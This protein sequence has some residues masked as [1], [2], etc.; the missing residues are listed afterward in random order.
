MALIKIAEHTPEWHALRLK[1]VGGSEIASLFH[2]QA[3]WG[4]SEY[5]LFCVKSGKIPAPPVDDSPGSRVWVGIRKEPT[6]AAMGAEI[7]GWKISKGLYAKDDT[8]SGM[9][10]SLDY[11]IDEPGPE[12]VKLGFEGPGVLQVKNVDGQVYRESWTSD[13]PPFHIL[14]QLQHEIACSGFTWGVI[15]PEVRG[16]EYPAFRYSARPKMI[17]LIRERVSAFWQRVRDNK[18]PLV[19]GTD[20]TAAALA[21]MFPLRAG[22]EELDLSTDNEIADICVGILTSKADLKGAEKMVTEYENRLKE[23]MRTYRRA[24]CNGYSIKGIYT[25]ANPGTRAGDLPADK[26]VGARK[27]SIWFRVNELMGAM[28]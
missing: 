3:N 5:T 28:A 8:I 21:A 1:H 22:D 27:E 7:H 2:Q 14:L 26:I 20:S 25:P 10:A 24:R 12:E 15:L 9:G 16:S 13:E 23:K 17:A 6:I 18:P 4:N 19:D 11:V